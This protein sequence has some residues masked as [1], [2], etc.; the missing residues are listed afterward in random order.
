MYKKIL[1]CLDNSDSANRG[2]DTGL[3]IAR[4]FSAS[5]TGCHVY[6]ARLHND[7]FRQMEGGLPPEYQKEEILKN[8]REV[9]DSLITKGLKIISDSYLAPFLAK[10]KSAGLDGLGVSREGKN[11]D[12]LVKETNEG[13]YDLVVM[14]SLGLGKTETSRIGSVT[15]RVARRV[16]TD[17]FISKDTSN[18]SGSITVAIDGSPSS[19]GGLL[20]AIKLSKALNLK[21][22]AISAFDPDFHQTA[23]RSIAGILSEEAGRV[24]RF[25]EQEQLH[26]AIIDKGLQRIYR[27]HLSTAS[28]MADKNN[29]YLKTTLL[30]GK[31]SNEIIKHVRKTN[32]FLLVLGRIGAHS[33][34]GLDIGSTTENCLREALCDVLISSKEFTPLINKSGGIEW[35]GEA[36]N[37]LTS[38]P[39]FARPI[40]RNMVEDAAR[41]NGILRITAS[42]MRTIRKDMEG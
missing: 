31:P 42:F 17:L 1:F 36:G 35:D 2:V 39:S 3:N 41:K 37:I 27:E 21:I 22:E 29:V 25:K 10:V 16:R 14:G 28:D 33:S 34:A 5:V 7:R 38:I 19:F 24:F 26:D 20:S 18:S 40:V 4:G 9:H 6:A 12:E 11:F 30:S 15:E 23:F 8:Q 32:P 13:G